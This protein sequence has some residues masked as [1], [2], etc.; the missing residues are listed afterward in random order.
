MSTISQLPLL[1]ESDVEAA[2]LNLTALTH[3]LAALKAGKLPTS[4]QLA[5]I[6]QKVLQS[7]ILQ[8]SLG[9]RVAG[10][11][12]GGKLSG[13]GRELVE[14][15]RE[16]IQATLRLGLEKN[17]DNKIQRFIWAASQAEVDV[18]G[19]IETPDLPVPTSAEINEARE[20]LR[21]LLSLL[22]TSPELRQLITDGINIFRDVFAD[23]AESVAQAAIE[24]TKASKKAAKSARPSEDDKRNG[25][26]GLEGQELPSAKEI[27]KQ[28]L[29]SL[30][31]AKDDA[32]K[33]IQ[34]KV[35]KARSYVDESMP[36][37]AKDAAIERFKQ[38]INNV[39]SNPQYEEAISTL[40]DLVKKYASLTTEA[41]KEAAEA[42]NAEV[43]AN[44]QANNAATLFREIIEAFTGPLDGVFRTADKVIKD[45]DGDE[46]IKL[47]FEDAE[48]LLDRAIHDPGYVTSSKAQ[49]RAED[50][51]DRAQEVVNSNA[52]W[53][54][55]AEALYKEINKAAD[56]AASDRALANL[57]KAMDRFGSAATKFGKRGMSLVDG[58]EVWGDL[59]QVLLPR[60]LSALQTIP[61]PRIEYT[62]ADFD[63]ALDSV[64]FTSAS[65]IPDAAYFTT[66]AEVSTKKG[67]AA[68]HTTF[69][70]STTLS[71]SGLRLQARDISSALDRVL[72]NFTL[73]NKK[74]GWI[75]LEDV[76]LL[77]VFIGSE[78]GDADDGL[79]VTLTIENPSEDDR[80]TFFV[81]KKVEVHVENFN[82]RIHDSQHPI[83]NFFAR[84]ALRSYLE[85]Q[86]T[87]V[88][89]EQI[90]H[91]FESGDVAFYALQQRAIGA[92][93][94]APDPLTYLRAVF[95]P[96]GAGSDVDVRDTGITKVGPQGEYILAIGVEEQLLPGKTGLGMQG[97]DIATRKRNVEGLME[98]GKASLEQARETA[99]GV[100][101]DIAEEGDRLADKLAEK[102]RDE[103]GDDGWKSDAFDL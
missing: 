83:R 17:D 89:E 75:G 29:R 44:P 46:R 61:L 21:E 9:S 18:E 91:L 16:V 5:N 68:Y 87:S 100:V 38:V 10:K 74:T 14:R 78:D 11:I 99:E 85:A 102:E 56:K 30:E 43:D 1:N 34:K 54:A 64:R 76:G 82:I 42:S 35:K 98:E 15:A 57:G 6:A 27:K 81:L 48:K 2:Q 36:T 86:F 32:Q 45:L 80:Q 84:P 33:T 59:T 69:N 103:R 39:Q 40:T 93:R 66:H 37:D 31:D 67:Y 25:R 7:N 65:F 92:G 72:T 94:A 47:L 58:R 96:S 23:A 63:L 49:R 101:E 24:T 4:D 55:D 97:K 51:Y 95:M 3:A 88:L 79:D 73:Q 41:V 53:K 52:A 20:A 8:P 77:D 90:T 26:T 62:S 22:L 19:K 60:F 70:S 50:I 28:T 13:P 71:I 12:G